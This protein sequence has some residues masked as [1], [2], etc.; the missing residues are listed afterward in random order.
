MTFI[1]ITDYKAAPYDPTTPQHRPLIAELRIKPPIKQR[2]ER[3]GSSRTK[4]R[5]F[6]EKKKKLSHSRDYQPLLMSEKP[7]TKLKKN[8]PQSSICNP[9]GH[10]AW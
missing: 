8:D 9:R 3:T 4:W 2:E 7:G 5:R 6:H 1:A 10:Q